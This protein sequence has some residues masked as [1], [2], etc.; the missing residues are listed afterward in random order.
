[1]QAR[2][3]CMCARMQ[4][5][6]AWIIE[7]VCMHEIADLTRSTCITVPIQQVK[8]LKHT[9]LTLKCNLEMYPQSNTKH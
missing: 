1:M 8:H 3:N 2:P 4:F 9:C 5:G 6:R 7:K